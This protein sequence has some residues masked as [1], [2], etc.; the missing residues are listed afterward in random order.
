MKQL[1]L[2]LLALIGSVSSAGAQMVENGFE[3]C[4]LVNYERQDRYGI[5]ERAMFE[6]DEQLSD[7]KIS[8]FRAKLGDQEALISV[9]LGGTFTP[10]DLRA[11][12]N[13]YAGASPV[14][15]SADTYQHF[16]MRY[17][18][19]TPTSTVRQGLVIEANDQL[20]TL[21]E[22][23]TNDVEIFETI[24][25][26]SSGMNYTTDKDQE[27]YKQLPASDYFET[28]VYCHDILMS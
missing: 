10:A 19:Q 25:M 11:R 16:K 14:M 24:L 12:T 7:D 17:D 8:F 13:F 26:N 5:P 6:R 28:G 3:N 18:I 20:A 4:Y 1:T 2:A 27:F 22:G 9:A 15:H 21:L 23:L